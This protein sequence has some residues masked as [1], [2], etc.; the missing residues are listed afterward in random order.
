MQAIISTMDTIT[1]HTVNTLDNLL[2]LKLE[3]SSS[4]PLGYTVNFDSLV[5]PNWTHRETLFFILLLLLA[6]HHLNA[7]L[8][9]LSA[10]L[11]NLTLQTILSK[12]PG[13]SSKLNAEIEKNRKI[14]KKSLEIA[15]DKFHIGLPGRPWNTHAILKRL[16]K[17]AKIEMD[18]KKEGKYSGGVFSTSRTLME[19]SAEASAKFMY[20]NVLFYD[21]HPASRQIENEVVSMIINLFN[22]HENCSGLATTGGSESILLGLL[23][24][25]RYFAKTKGITEPEVIFPETAHAAFYKAC[26]FFDI[27]ARVIPINKETYTVTAADYKRL[28]NKNTI[29]LVASAPNCAYGTFDP[30]SDLDGLAGQHNIGFFVDGC[31]GSILLPF[32]KEL[33]V[34]VS[35]PILD[36]RLKNL[37]M[38]TCDPHK[39]GLCPKGCSILMFGDQNIQ[40]ALYFG[41]T[42]WCGYL[43]ATAHFAG[44]RSSAMIAAAWAN[45]MYQGRDG[46]KQ[47]TK[48]IVEDTEKLK[49]GINKIKGLEVIGDPK[50]GNLSCRSVDPDLDI[51][52]L[53]NFLAKRGWNMPGVP[54]YPGLHLTIHPNNSAH[55]DELL[56]LLEEGVVEVKKN[57]GEYVEGPLKLLNDIL[58]VP[59]SISRNV[60]EECYHELFKRE[61]YIEHMRNIERQK[62]NNKR[63]R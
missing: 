57:P 26:E 58:A 43:Y 4:S 12:L 18:I 21:T 39:Y 63:R 62:K 29:C 20:T 32:L 59:G 3:P 28:I 23:A 45:L 49:N 54:K 55:L 5:P 51:Y 50:I 16:D 30:I 2:N 44:S 10:K 17:M 40:K 24:H 8:A 37:T 31:M 33:N 42:D 19:L 7:Y 61:N 25:K 36:F 11:S 15:D 60:L 1:Y 14:F 53:G 6:L 34:E 38:M 56:K 47:V 35:E 27:K 46:F 52:K 9:R 48:R 41:L 13:V 22:P